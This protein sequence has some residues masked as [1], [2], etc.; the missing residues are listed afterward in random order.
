MAQ[1]AGYPQVFFAVAEYRR[2]IRYDLGN[3]F[4]CFSSNR[5]VVSQI[6]ERIVFL[7]GRL[8][9]KDKFLWRRLSY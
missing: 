1:M 7:P 2:K 8:Y 5:F 4:T 9:G 3:G 6:V